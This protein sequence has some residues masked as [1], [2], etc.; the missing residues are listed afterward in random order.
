[1]IYI[2]NILKSDIKIIVEK[3]KVEGNGVILLTG[4]SSCGKGEVAKSL[5][6]F[7]S[8]PESKHLSMGDI[9]RRTVKKAKENPEF[10]NQ[11][12]SIYLISDNVSIFNENMNRPEIVQKAK[13]YIEE[14]QKYFGTGSKLISQFNWLEFCIEKGLL[15]PD[16]WTVKILDA[17]LVNSPEFLEGIFILDGYPRTIIAAEYMLKTLYNLRISIIKVIHLSITKEQMKIRAYGRNRSDDTEESL[18]R[19]YQFYIDKVQP[20]IDYLKKYLGSSVVM[21]DAHQPVYNENGQI[22]IQASINEVTISVMQALGLPR[23]LL[24]IE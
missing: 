9:L 24:D 16:E 23:F 1:M 3:V 12:S 21:I 11:L 7:L 10:L 20:C 14:V 4:P 5:C 13:A 8:I 18:E 2:Q 6:K 17:L 22:D 15:V 19:R